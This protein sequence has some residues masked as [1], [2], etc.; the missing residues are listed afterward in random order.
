M[1]WRLQRGEALPAV[2]L[3]QGLMLLRHYTAKWQGC[4]LTGTEG[5]TQSACHQHEKQQRTLI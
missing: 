2:A 1:T 5:A 4:L 3:Q